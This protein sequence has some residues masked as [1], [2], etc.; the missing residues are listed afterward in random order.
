MIKYFNELKL[1]E[2]HLP[3]LTVDSYERFNEKVFEQLK[4]I[5]NKRLNEITNFKDFDIN[6]IELLNIKLK[7]L[8]YLRKELL[9]G[10]GHKCD[11][12]LGFFVNDIDEKIKNMKLEESDLFILEEKERKD[13]TKQYLKPEST[14]IVEQEKY[15]FPT[16]ELLYEEN[17]IKEIIQSK[18]YLENKSNI[19]VGL[20]EE[21]N[22]RII[23][24]HETSHILIAGTTGI[25]KTTL[26]DNI[27]INILYKSSPLETKLILFDTNNNGLR[28]YDYIPHLLLPVITD[29]KKSVGTLAWIAQEIDNSQA[30][31][32]L[33]FLLE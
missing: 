27:I 33:I 8:A 15:E 9:L 21:E 26:L 10:Y 32:K 14:M 30:Q 19:M 6:S 5:Y 23:D 29:A 12:M 3:S 13:K 18:Q 7:K 2:K 11:K 16:I 28:L 22:I 1:L 20:K 31:L 25:G 24:L 4:E 17:E